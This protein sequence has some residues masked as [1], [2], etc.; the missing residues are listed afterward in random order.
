MTSPASVTDRNAVTTSDVTIAADETEKTVSLLKHENARLLTIVKTLESSITSLRADLQDRI[1]SADYYMQRLIVVEN[2]RDRLRDKLLS[3]QVQKLASLPDPGFESIVT[4]N[5]YSEINNN[6]VT[7]R[8]SDAFIETGFSAPPNLAVISPT[9]SDNSSTTMPRVSSSSIQSSQ[10]P[11]FAPPPS[12]AVKRVSPPPAPIIPNVDPIRPGTSISHKAVDSLHSITTTASQEEID[13]DADKTPT[14]ASNGWIIAPVSQPTLTAID[15]ATAT[16]DSASVKSKSTNQSIS[17]SHFSF[18]DAVDESAINWSTMGQHQQEHQQEH[19]QRDSIS[20]VEYVDEYEDDGNHE[21]LPPPPPQ[22]QQQQQQ[23]PTEF[24]TLDPK[25]DSENTT[26]KFDFPKRVQSYFPI[27]KDVTNTSVLSSPETTG[28]GLSGIDDSKKTSNHQTLASTIEAPSSLSSSSSSSS[29]SSTSPSFVQ[30]ETN[31]ADSPVFYPPLS[32]QQ[33]SATR[34]TRASVISATSDTK[35]TTYYE[36]VPILN[37]PDDTALLIDPGTLPTISINVV[38]SRRQQISKSSSASTSSPKSQDDPI[39]ILSIR[40]R[41]TQKEWWKVTKKLSVL[42]EL[43]DSLRK[44][45]INYSIPKL[46]DQSLFASLAPLKVDARRKMLEEYFSAILSIPAALQDH[47]AVV[48]CR[49]LSR[50]II[51]PMAINDTDVRKEGYLTKRGKNFGGWK[52]RYFVLNSPELEYFDSL[53]GQL[54]GTIKI[55]TAEYI[56]VLDSSEYDAAH[57]RRY[58]H[59]FQIWE[60]KRSS[61]SG[62]GGDNSKDVTKHILCAENDEDRDDWVIA[63]REFM[64][65]R[66][67]DQR[68]VLSGFTSGLS[69]SSSA[70]SISNLS[71]PAKKKIT[72][73]S[74][75]SPLPWKKKGVS[76]NGSGN[77]STGDMTYAQLNASTASVQRPPS[78]PSGS[79]FDI[80]EQSLSQF[81]KLLLPATVGHHHNNE[82][83]EEEKQDERKGHEHKKEVEKD[84][85]KE[86]K[87]SFFSLKKEVTSSHSASSAST[88]ASTAANAEKSLEINLSNQLQLQQQQREDNQRFLGLDLYKQ[89]PIY[90][91]R[92]SAVATQDAKK[93]IV[94]GQ[95]EHDAKYSGE[96]VRG[97]IKSINPTIVVS[98]FG[99]PLA[100]AIE[101]SFIQKGEVKLPS[102][103][104]RTIEYLEFQAAAQ[105]EGIFRLSGSNSVIRALKDRF[106]TEADVDLVQDGVRYDVHAVAG[107]LKLFLRE[108]PTPVLTADLQPEFVQSLEIQHE[109][110]KSDM[111]KILLRQLPHENFSLLKALSRYLINIVEKSEQNKMNIRNVG[112]VFAPTLNIPSE[113]VQ[114]FILDY[115]TLFIDH[116]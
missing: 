114:T 91:Y 52:I 110:S 37:M 48:I 69:T 96:I 72:G 62:S 79:T 57:E 2:E 1:Q 80:S 4:D 32:P 18:E 44:V 108:L 59:A 38:S 115:A 112:I 107:L 60:R 77:N 42:N 26:P 58:R 5:N 76:N 86:K 63:L 46:P 19:Q 50:D 102:V 104:Y 31:P 74:L 92:Q 49:F 21:I 105:Q 8:S 23:K 89:S 47:P 55:D 85:R 20:S 106:N 36:N 97:G 24:K 109:Q 75:V 45:L 16:P 82:E 71:S 99:L 30:T 3:C 90:E 68:S 103:V 65:D 61:G 56:A 83:E 7:N 100:Q 25:Y 41:G 94:G 29:S 39:A 67:A 66:N 93:I 53:G 116:P 51:D 73:L 17:S 15:P 12:P 34:H 98:I 43:D 9:I 88:S 87:R 78:P 81:N 13:V 54:L 11:L 95:C 111:F 22:Q 35:G 14:L 40:D 6:H 70:A 27:S 101:I 33:T 113:L 64:N 28:L 84:L 10:Q